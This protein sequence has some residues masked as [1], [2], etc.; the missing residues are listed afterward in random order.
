MTSDRTWMRPVLTALFAWLTVE[1]T[2]ASLK[3]EDTRAE[4]RSRLNR[5]ALGGGRLGSIPDGQY[6]DNLLQGVLALRA[7]FD[8]P[9]A[10]AKLE[11]NIVMRSR[12]G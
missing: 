2:V 12:R 11:R 1:E 5:D 3:S 8:E 6:G 10:G 7:K 9:T 4:L